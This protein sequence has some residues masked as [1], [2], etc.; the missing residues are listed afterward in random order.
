MITKNV[1]FLSLWNLRG[2]TLLW[3]QRDYTC[4]LLVQ[5]GD[6]IDKVTLS[7]T[8]ALYYRRGTFNFTCVHIK[9]TVL[10]KLRKKYCYYFFYC[11]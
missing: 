3:L 2:H 6:C 5:R 10:R 7:A 4:K 8:F 9:N 11:S 1:D